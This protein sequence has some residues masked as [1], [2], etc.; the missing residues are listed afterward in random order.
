MSGGEWDPALWQEDSLPPGEETALFFT[1]SMRADW[2][3]RADFIPRDNAI[4]LVS[5]CPCENGCAA[6][7]GDHWLDKSLVLWGLKNLQGGVSAA[8]EIRLN[9][10]RKSLPFK[11][12]FF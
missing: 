7:I 6:C 1:T 8:E 9:R 12:P 3:M 11:S 10:H 4:T 5:G 2:G